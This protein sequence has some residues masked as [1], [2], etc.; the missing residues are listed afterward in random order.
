VKRGS[1]L[2]S[3]GLSM[4]T[5]DSNERHRENIVGAPRKLLR[6]S[7]M[8]GSVQLHDPESR[9]MKEGATKSFEQCYNCQAPWTTRLR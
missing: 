3:N 8:E 1:G 5:R 2:S 9:I 6:K 4:S 7:R